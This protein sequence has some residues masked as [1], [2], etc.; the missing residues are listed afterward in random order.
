M[1]C[2]LYKICRRTGLALRLKKDRSM[3]ELWQST[4]KE[5]IKLIY[6]F[7]S[8]VQFVSDNIVLYI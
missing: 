5:K 7:T 4:K 3:D 2:G 6:G 1:S 8:L